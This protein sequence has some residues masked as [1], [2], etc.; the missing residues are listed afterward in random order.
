MQ[1]ITHDV[2]VAGDDGRCFGR[3]LLGQ[4]VDI[5]ERVKEK[6]GLQLRFQRIPFGLKS[7]LV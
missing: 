1:H 7:L 3:A 6:M 5:V 2:G 4:C